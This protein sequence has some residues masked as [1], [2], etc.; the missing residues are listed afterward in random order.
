MGEVTPVECHIDSYS[1]LNID[2]VKTHGT[3]TLTISPLLTSHTR[4]SS[5][6][7]TY[8]NFPSKDELAVGEQMIPKACKGDELPCEIYI[9]A[10]LCGSMTHV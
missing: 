6:P 2:V 8:A 10:H 4:T 7:G 9:G 1:R 5:H 3:E